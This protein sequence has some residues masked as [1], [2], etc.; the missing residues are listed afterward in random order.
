MSRI[1]LSATKCANAC[2]VRVAHLNCYRS[3]QSGRGIRCASKPQRSAHQSGCWLQSA[4]EPLD[5][6]ILA[7][8]RG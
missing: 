8:I 3:H 2:A 6:S 1:M 7:E 4:S 5:G